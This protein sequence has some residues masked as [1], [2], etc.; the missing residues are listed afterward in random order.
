MKNKKRLNRNVYFANQG[1]NKTT[2]NNFFKVR[3]PSQPNLRNEA[4]QTQ[5]S[6]REAS[7]TLQNKSS[8]ALL[9]AGA[10][11]L[12][13]QDSLFSRKNLDQTISGQQ[14]VPATVQNLQPMEDHDDALLP[15]EALKKKDIANESF[16]ADA[17][18]E[19]MERKFKQERLVLGMQ[20]KQTKF[21]LLMDSLDQQSG[22][23]H[24][25]WNERSAGCDISLCEKRADYCLQ[26]IEAFRQTCYLAMHERMAVELKALILQAIEL[27]M[28]R[29]P[30]AG[31]A[32]VIQ[33]RNKK[34]R[35]VEG[36]DLRR[37]T[38]ALQI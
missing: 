3:G 35:T 30:K 21:S 31:N 18:K 16:E 25:N 32:F 9:V 20:V 12:H 24:S 10:M 11:R 14:N 34:K 6:S 8:K 5:P 38:S 1:L 7:P 33:A 15:K 2:S 13:M 17:D 37:S 4:K 28:N 36:I 29:T 27:N 23:G 26:Q 22:E 19:A